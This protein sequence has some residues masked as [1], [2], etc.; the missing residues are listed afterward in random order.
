VALSTHAA[1]LDG[2]G[3]VNERAEGSG[4]LDAASFLR[5]VERMTMKRM[6]R[7]CFVCLSG[8]HDMDGSCKAS[9]AGSFKGRGRN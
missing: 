5:A 8:W 9:G 3:V 6:E 7:R 1:A 4:S 2:G